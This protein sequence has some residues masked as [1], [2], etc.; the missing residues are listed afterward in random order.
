MPPISISVNIDATNQHSGPV[1]H[2]FNNSLPIEPKQIWGQHSPLPPPPFVSR[3]IPSFHPNSPSS[4]LLP[5]KVSTPSL[6]SAW[7]VAIHLSYPPSPHAVQYQ[8]LLQV[9]KP[10]GNIFLFLCSSFHN[11]F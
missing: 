5:V 8:S 1:L 6:V 3:S 2:A 7:S 11:C 10:H 4:A 9:D